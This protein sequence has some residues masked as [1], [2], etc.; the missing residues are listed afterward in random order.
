[1]GIHDGHRERMRQRYDQMGADGFHDHEMLE[2]LLSCAL[3]RVDTNPIA[4]QL[5]QVYGSL[6]S[7]CNAP[8]ESLQKIPGIGP[9]A[10]TL[11]RLIPG[12][13][14]MYYSEHETHVV[15]NTPE[16]CANYLIPQFIGR[17]VETV[18]L[19]CTDSKH[20]LLSCTLLSTGSLTSA[21]V[22]PRTV[23]EIA[24][25]FNAAHVVLAH[26][27][28]NGVALPS[29]DDLATT[30]HLYKALSSVSIHFLDHI[31]VADNDYVSMADSG[32]F[33]MCA[34]RYP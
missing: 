23:V 16:K 3:P 19:L 30:N 9:N 2:M 12:L 8:R 18:F 34:S 4:H 32:Y 31:I 27:H 28:P 10:A 6:N 11:L 26:N 15:L 17:V 22:D 5:L 20:R 7:I 13:C 21:S 29:D 24:L 14:R 33:F 1:M 25:R